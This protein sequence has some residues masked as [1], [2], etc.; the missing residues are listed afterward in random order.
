L[1]HEPVR[2]VPKQEGYTVQFPRSLVN[3]PVQESITNDGDT[4]MSMISL[5]QTNMTAVGFTFTFTDNYRL[6]GVSPA[7]A[8]ITITSPLGESKSASCR[9]GDV[10][11]AVLWFRP[12]CTPPDNTTLMAWNLTEAQKKSRNRYPEMM[13]GTGDW[14]VEVTATREYMTPVHPVASSITWS[15]KSKVECYRL[16]VSEMYN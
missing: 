13:N 15:V 4:G 9:P 10:T 8:E 16:E 12:L 3:G 6:S 5:N 2:L 7:G 1:Y 11:C 14:T